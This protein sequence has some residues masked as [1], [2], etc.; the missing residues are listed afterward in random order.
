MSE[1]NTNWIETAVLAIAIIAI[2]CGV[3]FRFNEP[4]SSIPNNDEIYNFVA[5]VKLNTAHPKYDPRYYNF[6]HPF[7]G[8]QLMGLLIDKDKNY[9][10]T[11]NISVNL[12]VYNYLASLELRE[13]ENS[14]R[15]MTAFFGLLTIIPVFL[16]ARKWYGKKTA[17]IAAGLFSISVG[18]I[19]Q[20]RIAFPDAFLPFFLLMSIYFGMELFLSKPEDKMAGIPAK[21][22]YWIALFVFLTAGFLVR[23]GQPLLVLGVLI[24]IYGTKKH[25]L[26]KLTAMIPLLGA[27]VAW[28]YSL[29]A[30]DEMIKLQSGYVSAFELKFNFLQGL[31]S[32]QGIAF[33][34]LLLAGIGMWFLHSKKLLSPKQVWHE[35]HSLNEINQFFVMFIIFTSA[36]LMFSIAGSLPRYYQLFMV[37]PIILVAQFIASNQRGKLIPLLFCVLVIADIVL[38]FGVNPHFAEYSVVGLQPVYIRSSEKEFSLLQEKLQ[39]IGTEFYFTDSAP[40]IMR[41]LKAKPFPPPITKPYIERKFCH[42]D[43]FSQSE[44]Y[45]FV[46]A[47]NEPLEENNYLCQEILGHERTLLNTIPNDENPIYKIYEIHVPARLP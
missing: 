12:Y 33:A 16:I 7:L 44:S 23:T 25:K 9:S 31:F 20:A 34:V 40:L 29:V 39:A 17:V 6:E 37:F 1:R 15:A 30:I 35:F 27:V 38:L 46:Y 3:Y 2:L 24:L 21:W 13:Q 41:D 47:H 42:P 5:A 4:L 11:Q 36:G 18:F 32:L 8:K 19:N 26:I 43:S 45:I 22:I 14:F 28:G 10:N